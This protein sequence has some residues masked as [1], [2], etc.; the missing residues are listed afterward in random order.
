MKNVR[1]SIATMMTVVLASAV[2]ADAG[3]A[4]TSLGAGVYTKE[5]AESGKAIFTQNCSSCHNAD[6]YKTVLQTWRGQPLTYLFEQ[7]MS[8]MPADKPGALLDT[9]YEDAISYVLEIVGFPAGE[10]RLEYGN[11]MM[12]D[13][14]IEAAP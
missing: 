14:S 1:L 12:D 9:E 3:A 8:A 13:I 4:P 5:Q 6:Y 11:G 2:C 10:T 7:V